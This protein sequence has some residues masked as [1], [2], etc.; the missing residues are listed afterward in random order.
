VSLKLFAGDAF[1]GVQNDAKAMNHL[2]G[3]VAVVEDRSIGSGEL[4]FAFVRGTD[5]CASA[6]SALRLASDLAD[7]SQPHTGSGSIGQR[8]PSR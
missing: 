8:I 5:R 3:N 1:L 4:L 2:S 6:C 7:P